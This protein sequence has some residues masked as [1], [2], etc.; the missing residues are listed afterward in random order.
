MKNILSNPIFLMAT[1]IL[2][3]QLL[4]NVSIK[5]IK[6]GSSVTLF[7]A[8]LL[9]Y[10]LQKNL[11]INVSLDKSIFSVALVGFM[12]SVGL[13]A[14]KNI[15]K[16]L[17]VYGFRFI[18]LSF[19]ITG[20]GALST[21][22]FLKGLN[23]DYNSVIGTYVGALTS[24]PGLA[25][26]I[27]IS[28]QGAS[29][30]LGYAIAY[31]PGVLV[32]ILFAQ[33]MKGFHTETPRQKKEEV[34]DVDG[35][36]MSGFMAVLAFGVLIGQLK[37]NIY[38]STIS[39]GATGGVL[40]S[41]LFLGSFKKIGPI[42]FEFNKKQL[43]VIRDI[44]LNMFLAV[45]GLNYGY[46]AM[47]AVASSGLSLLL[48]GL[49]TGLLSIIVGFFVGKYILKIKDVYL[50]G[51]ICGGMTSTPGLAAAIEAFEEEKVVAGYGAT[52]PFALIF[53][54]LWT[55]LLFIASV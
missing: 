35:F 39:L 12:V 2:I 6:L 47:E 14:S 50:I 29:V 18:I 9:S 7:V 33:I 23:Q 48:I 34:Q 32:V 5:K 24:S 31:V 54:I 45:V 46:K 25:A 42:A 36:S 40:T 37:I 30:G 4:G 43:G 26:A 27:E 20:T 10:I 15:K 44:S 8:L 53:M 52:Y 19:F 49:T 41:A 16:T 21:Y 22:M 11:Q 51:G 3:G 1:C 17:K 55:N 13:M 28:T 38:Q